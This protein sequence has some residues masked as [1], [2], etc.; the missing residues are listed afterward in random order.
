[1]IKLERA[2]G[3]YDYRR[4]TDEENTGNGYEYKRCKGSHFMY[5]NGTNTVA[6]NNH[7]NKMVAQRIIKQYHLQVAG[8]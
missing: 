7:L 3:Q 6:V 1:M 5:S 4:K 2:G 8:V